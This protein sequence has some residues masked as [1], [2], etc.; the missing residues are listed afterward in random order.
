MNSCYSHIVSEQF[1][2]SYLS[3]ILSH[4]LSVFS[5]SHVHNHSYWHHPVPPPLQ[6]RIVHV[7][8]QVPCAASEPP[9]IDGRFHLR[10][11]RNI[12]TIQLRIRHHRG[13]GTLH[14]DLHNLVRQ[15]TIQIVPVVNHLMEHPQ[16]VLT[17]NTVPHQRFGHELLPFNI[18]ERDLPHHRGSKNLQHIPRDMVFIS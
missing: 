6:T 9:V 16:L 14:A 5:I 12:I 3:V 2:Y 4:R 1:L 10:H 7:P 8:V 17:G 13:N 18:R 15:S 11:K